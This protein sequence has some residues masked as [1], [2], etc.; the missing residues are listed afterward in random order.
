MLKEYNIQIDDEQWNWLESTKYDKNKNVVKNSLHFTI[1]GFKL[2]SSAI[3]GQLIRKFKVDLTNQE[4]LVHGVI[5]EQVYESNKSLRVD[6]SVKLDDPSRP[7]RQVKDHH[8]LDRLNSYVT[9]VDE[10]DVLLDLKF[11]IVAKRP[12]EQKAT[13][14][15]R[16]KNMFYEVLEDYLQNIRGY[17]PGT[18]LIENIKVDESAPFQAIVTLKNEMYC[19]HKGANHS[20]A[21]DIYFTVNLLSNKAQQRCSSGNCRGSMFEFEHTS[22]FFGTM[23]V[24][25]PINL[26]G[27]IQAFQAFSLFMSEQKPLKFS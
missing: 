15:P 26:N 21:N 20:S 11:P 14:C 22:G 5:D 18:C 13:K 16:N 4:L 27:V 25:T 7:M 23:F 12:R 10:D 24:T 8:S 9:N 1:S 6:G 2:S 3:L 17:T 19:H